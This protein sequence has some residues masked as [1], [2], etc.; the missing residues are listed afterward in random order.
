MTTI[1]R[2][3][4]KT[5]SSTLIARPPQEVFDFVSDLSSRPR[6]DREVVSAEWTSESPIRAGSTYEAAT[7]FLGRKIKIAVEITAWDPPTSWSYRSL[8]G[9]IQMEA[10]TTCE[11][12]GNGTRVTETSQAQLSG[13]FKLAEGLLGKQLQKDRDKV[14]AALRVLLEAE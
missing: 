2:H 13:F 9:P 8:S 14:L 10:M 7:G 5:Q 6:W 11:A 4:I 12:E 3:V 1:P